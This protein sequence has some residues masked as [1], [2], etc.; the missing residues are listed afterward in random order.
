MKNQKKNFQRIKGKKLVEKFRVGRYV[1]NT[2]KNAAEYLTRAKFHNFECF[3]L[4]LINLMSWIIS[5]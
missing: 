4:T 5:N 3:L 1:E 2:R